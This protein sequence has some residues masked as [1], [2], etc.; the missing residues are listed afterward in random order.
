MFMFW[1]ACP[2][3]PLTMLSIA[4]IAMNVLV[5]LSTKIETSQKFVYLMLWMSALL[6][7][8]RSRTNGSS[9]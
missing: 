2:A 9:P 5:R 8:G 3:A 4:L 6:P 1:I 7:A